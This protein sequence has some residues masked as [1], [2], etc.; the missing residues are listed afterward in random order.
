MYIK[1]AAH[2]SNTQREG[3]RALLEGAWPSY[4]RAFVCQWSREVLEAADEAISEEENMGHWPCIWT[5]HEYAYP[6][7]RLSTFLQSFLD[8]PEYSWHSAAQP[9]T[10]QGNTMPTRSELTPGDPGFLEERRTVLLGMVVRAV[11]EYLLAEQEL[12]NKVQV[13]RGENGQT[14]EHAQ[15]LWESLEDCSLKKTELRWLR[16]KWT[17]MV[18]DGV[19]LLGD[20]SEKST[21]LVI[22]LTEAEKEKGIESQAWH[23]WDLAVQE[24]WK[25]ACSQPM[26]SAESSL[27]S[28]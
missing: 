16:V 4:E 19:Y 9:V 15:A 25:E 8:D 18:R 3:G 6:G 11:K 22:H 12:A 26:R 27:E 10:G 14:A 20:G 7:N 2:T 13:C 28:K 23:F 21:Q 24:G 1:T 5:P 17:A